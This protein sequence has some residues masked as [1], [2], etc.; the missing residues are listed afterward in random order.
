MIRTRYGYLSPLLLVAVELCVTGIVMESVAA[1]DEAYR[2]LAT[3][4]R[5]PRSGGGSI[6]WGSSTSDPK[7]LVTA[8]AGLGKTHAY[9]VFPEIVA[10]KWDAVRTELFGISEV[11]TTPVPDPA[12]VS[13]MLDDSDARRVTEAIFAAVGM[14]LISEANALE[15]LVPY[16]DEDSFED[17]ETTVAR[18]VGHAHYLRRHAKDGTWPHLY[19]ADPQATLPTS[20]IAEP[21]T[22][23]AAIVNADDAETGAPPSPVGH[24]QP[25]V[26]RPAPDR[27]RVAEPDYR[28]SYH[29]DHALRVFRKVS[30]EVPAYRAFL[31]RHGLAAD[32]IRTL[33]DFT[34]VPPTTHEDLVSWGCTATAVWSASTG[35][36]HGPPSC[37]PRAEAA[38]SANIELHDRILR[39]FRAHRRRTLVVSGFAMGGWLGST[40]TPQTL[41]GLKGRGHKLSVVV[42]GI[43][44]DV[45]A[46]EI[47]AREHDYEQIVLAGEQ[48]FLQEVLDRADRSALK[49]NLHILL[50][51]RNITESWRDRVVSMV[52]SRGGQANPVLLYGNADTGILGHETPSTIEIR[53]MARDNLVL[54]EALFGGHAGGLPTLVEYD[55]QRVYAELDTDRLLVT[56]DSP[57]SLVRYRINDHARI[58]DPEQLV[59]TLRDHGYTMPV[60][61]TTPGAGFLVIDS[62]EET[63]TPKTARIRLVGND[64]ESELNDLVSW[65]YHEDALR[66]RVKVETEKRTAQMSAVSQVLTVV[67]ATGIAGVA[68]TTA[69][70]LAATLSTWLNSRRPRVTIEITRADGRSTTIREGELPAAEETRELLEPANG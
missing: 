47:S 26:D 49:Q 11:E 61:T 55:P 7:P 41:A 39:S 40:C 35:S 54:A 56:I 30:C 53:R 36:L 5:D 59:A 20:S 38:S 51:G 21:D 63:A 29:C 65:L 52:E 66:G 2:T 70:V 10:E 46:R 33:N 8:V 24:H 23:S 69:A 9:N 14:F 13:K 22:A 62:T 42:P 64:A 27:H 48:S 18:I 17:L 68:G 32:R 15:E 31:L 19:A 1:L 4:V 25:L 58:L 67:F 37:W 16:D 6:R 50:T 28:G 43:D 45:V 12:V 44:P 3:R 34:R 57:V 60:H